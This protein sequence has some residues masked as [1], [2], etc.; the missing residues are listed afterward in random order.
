MIEIVKSGPSLQIGKGADAAG[1]SPR[2]AFGINRVPRNDYLIRAHEGEK[3][4]TKQEANQY[5][6]NSSNGSLFLDKLADTIIVREEADIDK[7][8]RKINK[9]ISCKSWRRFVNYRAI[10][11][12]YN[13][14]GLCYE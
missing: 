6:R 7:I 5:K 3:L 10:I 1:K 13:L 12:V 9:N 11:V 2:K 14:Q 4:L 8:V